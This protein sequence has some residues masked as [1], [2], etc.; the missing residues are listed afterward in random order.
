MRQH[1][2]NPDDCNEKHELVKK[3][4]D[5]R[6]KAKEQVRSNLKTSPPHAWPL[7]P[8]KEHHFSMILHTNEQHRL[9]M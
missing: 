2:G 5:M 9:L 8:L 6:D 7:S 4:T 3:A 1:G